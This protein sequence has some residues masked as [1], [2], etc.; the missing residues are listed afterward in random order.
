MLSGLNGDDLGKIKSYSIQI[1]KHDIKKPP[2]PQLLVTQ[3][4]PFPTVILHF[5]PPLMTDCMVYKK[6][7]FFLVAT[8]F[9]IEIETLRLQEIYKNKD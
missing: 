7:K 5:L 6:H 4:T 9:Q 2:N 1:V 8:C 3:S